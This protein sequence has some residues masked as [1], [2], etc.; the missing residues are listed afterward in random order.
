MA[1]VPGRQRWW[2]GRRGPDDAVCALVSG[3]C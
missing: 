1:S 2:R 3:I